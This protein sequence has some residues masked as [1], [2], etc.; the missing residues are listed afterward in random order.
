[1]AAKAH[2][3]DVRTSLLE[4][5]ESYERIATMAELNQGTSDPNKSER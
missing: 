4:L 3:A 1:M 5:A 2:D